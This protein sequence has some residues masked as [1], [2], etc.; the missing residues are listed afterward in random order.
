MKTSDIIELK[1]QIITNIEEVANKNIKAIEDKIDTGLIEI[2]KEA[3][4][5]N[6]LLKKEY[7]ELIQE[8]KMTSKELTLLAPQLKENYEFIEQHNKR[9]KFFNHLISNFE[10][11]RQDIIYLKNSDDLIL[12]NHKDLNVKFDTQ[13]EVIE[14]SNKAI[15]ELKETIE[16]SKEY[17]NLLEKHTDAMDIRT[18]KILNDN[19]KTKNLLI[20]T[21][22]IGI[23]TI[24]TVIYYGSK[25]L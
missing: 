2:K 16:M 3:E 21:I 10:N 14:M 25:I 18:E 12:N 6:N 24:G 5:K 7:D 9:E 1:D 23:A 17:I 19:N 15:N 22:L 11:L 20:T 4:I 8:H 13:F